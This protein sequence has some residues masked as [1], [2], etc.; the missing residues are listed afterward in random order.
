M[1]LK[2]L[3]LIEDDYDEKPLEGNEVCSFVIKISG[4]KD[5]ID[6]YLEDVVNFV[7]AR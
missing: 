6:K 4:T 3:G 1:R 7:R 2:K 5:N